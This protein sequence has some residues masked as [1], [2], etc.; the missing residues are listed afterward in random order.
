MCDLGAVGYQPQRGELAGR[1]VDLVGG[2]LPGVTVTAVGVDGIRRQTVTDS[3]GR[4]VI[5][6]LPSGAITVTGELAGFTTLRRT[7]AYDRDHPRPLN[8]QME[9]GGVTETLTV[10]GG[11]RNVAGEPPQNVPS[12]NVLNLQRRVAGVLP[13]RVDVPRAG[14]SYRFVRPLVLDEETT[15]SFRYKKR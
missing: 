13:V 10:S 5:R 11:T 7:L 6:G 8:M 15:V 3:N 12:Q 4:Y 14:T 9:I 2:L 1:A